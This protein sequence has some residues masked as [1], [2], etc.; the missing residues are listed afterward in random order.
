[1][2]SIKRGIDK[3]KGY[4]GHIKIDEQG[5]IIESRNVE[6]PAKLAEVINFNLKRGNE[7]AREL[8]FNKM[9]GFAIFGEKESLVF[10][11]GL[12]VVV[13]SQ[14]VDWQDVFTYYTFNVA[15]CATG[16]V[17]TVLSLIL[18]YIAIFTNFMYFL[19]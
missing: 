8:G 7:E 10:M 9:N 12:G 15:F 3:L 1:M 19:A 14:K 4:V 6:N 2:V 5:K 16:V 17:L 11:K 18:F 13:D